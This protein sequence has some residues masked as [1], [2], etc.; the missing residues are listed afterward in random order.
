MGK[1][2]RALLLEHSSRQEQRRSAK[3]WRRTDGHWDYLVE[4][5][6]KQFK[7][8]VKSAKRIVRHDLNARLDYV[9]VESQNVRGKV[10]GCLARQISSRL[11]RNP[12][13]SCQTT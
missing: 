11:R 13:I 2:G 7:V 9:W 6:D 5:E 8:V 3:R 12:L 4:K 1:R 10:A